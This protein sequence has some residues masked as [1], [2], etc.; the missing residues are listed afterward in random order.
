MGICLSAGSG[1][2][3]F[4]PFFILSLAS[5]SGWIESGTTFEWIGTYPALIIF[6]LAALLELI[7][8]YCPWIDNVLDLVATPVSIITGIILTSAVITDIN[9][10]LK[11]FLVIILGG[12]ASLNVQLLTVKARALSSVFPS[13]KGNF[14]VTT[15][16]NISSIAI[17]VLAII[18]PTFSLLLIVVIVYLIYL[19]IV[20]EKKEKLSDAT[21]LKILI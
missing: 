8:F 14:L 19:K 5:F 9:P 13:G 10:F 21:T 16:E 4:I 15:I 17:S 18:I 20:K 11:W 3:L 1:F 2:R 12:G 6:G 7:G